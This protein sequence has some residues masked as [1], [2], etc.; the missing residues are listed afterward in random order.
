[1][2]FAKPAMITLQAASYKN[3]AEVNAWP[4]YQGEHAQMDYALRNHGWLREY[5]DKPATWCY[6][7]RTQDRPIGF[8]LLSTTAR[9]E[10]EFR[11]AMH[12]EAL[13]HGY[14]KKLA[15]MI[16]KH[17]FVRRGLERIHLIVRKNNPAASRLYRNLGFVPR[18]Q[19]VREIQGQAI[20][21][22]IMDIDKNLF[23]TTNGK[24]I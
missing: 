16:I 20:V 22:Q 24:D 4:P 5:I 15:L 23:L 10:A 11:I 13:G 6:M 2:D 3:I 19:C 18:G 12:P 21:F 9:H 14:G 8:A 1:M 17:G 7:A